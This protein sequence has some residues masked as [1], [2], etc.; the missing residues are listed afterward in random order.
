MVIGVRYVNARKPHQRKGVGEMKPKRK[1]K[2]ELREIPEKG[3]AIDVVQ[4]GVAY[5][6]SFVA[7]RSYT[8]DG[9]TKNVCLW[10]IVGGAQLVTTGLKGNSFYAC[11]SSVADWVMGVDRGEFPPGSKAQ[12]LATGQQVEKRVI[13]ARGYEDCEALLTKYLYSRYD[14][15]ECETFT[16]K[17]EDGIPVARLTLKGK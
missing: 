8:F 12:R 15:M 1:Y 16:A 11:N 10:R 5:R 13:V 9:E 4:G 6:L 3:S 2:I 7:C 14:G 17:Y